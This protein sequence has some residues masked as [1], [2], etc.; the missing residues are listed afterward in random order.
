MHAL[1]APV[2]ILVASA[3]C[4]LDWPSVRTEKS[5]LQLDNAGP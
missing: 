1:V 4:N 5:E 3:G 2:R